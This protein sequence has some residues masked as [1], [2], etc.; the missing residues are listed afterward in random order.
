M[1]RKNVLDLLGGMD[2][3]KVLEW[4][5][6]RITT[7]FASFKDPVL[8]TSKPLFEILASIEPRSLDKDNVKEG[9]TPEDVELNAKYVI[10]VA[11]RLGATCFLVWEDIKDAKPG[12][13]MTFIASLAK[14][15]ETYVKE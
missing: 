14:T 7:K 15:A 9:L 11:R 1:V 6:S 4:A 8:K 12:M 10:S 2:E 13:L 5:N 3:A